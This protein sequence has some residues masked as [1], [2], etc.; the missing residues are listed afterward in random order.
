M[1]MMAWSINN[2]KILQNSQHKSY[3]AQSPK[4]INCSQYS[5]NVVMELNLGTKNNVNIR[6]PPE[7]FNWGS[8]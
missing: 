1:P 4:D 7:L 2:I 8:F 5:R 6:K 3:L